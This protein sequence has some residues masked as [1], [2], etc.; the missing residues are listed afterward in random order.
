MKHL[1]GILVLTIFF[2]QTCYSSTSEAQ[3]MEATS[4][5]GE[6]WNLCQNINSEAFIPELE[7]ASN[8]FSYIEQDHD[9]ES[10]RDSLEKMLNNYENLQKRTSEKILQKSHIILILILVLIVI[11]SLAL[12][13]YYRFTQKRLHAENLN[14]ILFHF[15]EQNKE[16][17]RR[18]AEQEQER[19]KLVEQLTAMQKEKI[20]TIQKLEVFL[21]DRRN[22]A[23]LN[24][25]EQQYFAGQDHWMVMLE[26][27]D[28]VY[29]GLHDRINTDY[30]SISELEKRVLLLSPFKLSRN[31]E[32][33]LLGISTSVLDK[34]R[35]RI[36][37]LKSLDFPEK[38]LDG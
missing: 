30:P 29:P 24:D 25:L 17:L 27:I 26:V 23:A 15:I 21:K 12:V 2:S 6:V 8:Y 9:W 22:L 3:L 34:V 33:T 1:P 36:R 19:L 38:S 11:L 16:L 28:M 5:Q 32:A 31:D 7:K 37:K 20:K 13:L 35:G 14:N 10:V 4:K 18:G